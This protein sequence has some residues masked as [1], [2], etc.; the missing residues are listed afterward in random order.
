M[1]AGPGP[2]TLISDWMPASRHMFCTASALA[3]K[4]PLI[5]HS[6]IL[7]SGLPY[8]ASNS[9]ALATRTPDTQC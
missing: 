9:L 8:A 1:A 3:W 5:V 6:S 2:I 7:G 4:M